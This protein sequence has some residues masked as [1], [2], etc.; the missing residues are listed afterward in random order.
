MDGVDNLIKLIG[1]LALKTHWSI[2]LF[3]LLQLIKG[4]EEEITFTIGLAYM[5]HSHSSFEVYIDD[6]T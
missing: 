4:R 1:S 2:G 6:R 5:A 3:L